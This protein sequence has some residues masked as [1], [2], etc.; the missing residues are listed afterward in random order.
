VR[1]LEKAMELARTK[2]DAVTRVPEEEGKA[3][4]AV[5]AQQP[6]ENQNTALAA[7][8]RQA[9]VLLDDDNIP[10]ID[11]CP[12]SEEDDK[13]EEGVTE[14]EEDEEVGPL[15]APED[16]WRPKSCS[17]SLRTGEGRG[18]SRGS[19]ASLGAQ[20]VSGVGLIQD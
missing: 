7:P 2:V 19:V 10:L 16:G 9:S 8:E 6:D 20:P 5:K 11:L 17:L 12:S 3:V 1:G 14:D 18:R 4:K 13:E 15:P